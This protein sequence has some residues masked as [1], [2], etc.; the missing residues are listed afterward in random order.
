[1]IEKKFR[2]FTLEVGDPVVVIRG[3]SWEQVGWG[4]CQ[5]PSLSRTLNG[6]ILCSWSVGQDSIEGYEGQSGDGGPMPSSAVSEDGG[7]TWR[8]TTPADKAHG[9]LCG[10][11]KEY[12]GPAAKNAYPAA[13]TSE[14]VPVYRTPDRYMSVFRAGDVPGDS[15]CFTA[16]E[17]DPVSG[18]VGEFSSRVNWPHRAVLVFRSGERDLVYPLEC[19]MGILGQT[20]P[21]GEGG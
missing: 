5:F 11:G 9:V 2:D 14:A 18:K 20:I 3:P 21:D 12:L 8:R 19:E 13:W 6:Q 4:P 17:I 16:R 15:P 7:R 10:S 1:M